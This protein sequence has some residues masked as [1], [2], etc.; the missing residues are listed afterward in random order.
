MITKDYF[1]NLLLKYYNTKKAVSK[2]T[3][4]SIYIDSPKVNYTTSIRGNDSSLIR[5]FKEER[6]NNKQILED[7]QN[8]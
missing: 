8:E 1:N 4:Q 6:K 7:F 2:K 3:K 5:E